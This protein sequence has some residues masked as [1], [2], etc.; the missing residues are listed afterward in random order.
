MQ[1]ILN[2]YCINNIILKFLAIL[3]FAMLIHLMYYISEQ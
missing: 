2:I 1:I 3:L